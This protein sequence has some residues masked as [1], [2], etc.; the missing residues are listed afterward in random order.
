M[1]DLGSSAIERGEY[2]IIVDVG[3]N[4]EDVINSAKELQY[5]QCPD[6]NCECPNF[7]NYFYP[8]YESLN[9]SKYWKEYSGDLFNHSTIWIAR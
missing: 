6:C 1:D 9:W 5:Q 4:Y 8:Y 7:P 3:D 2:K